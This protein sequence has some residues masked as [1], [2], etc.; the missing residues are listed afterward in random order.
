MT[1]NGKLCG[2][3]DAYLMGQDGTMM[4]GARWDNT[5]TCCSNVSI[6]LFT[7]HNFINLLLFIT[8]M[9]RAYRKKT[10]CG[11]WN[12]SDV[13]TT[14]TAVKNGE[15]SLREASQVYKI[16][17]STLERHKNNKVIKPG[18]LGRYST[19]LDIDYLDCH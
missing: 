9:V 4:I 2:I 17:K 18:S 10:T 7:S 13:N 12:L 15:L 1:D 5:Y 14:I 16:P 3:S 19:V 6:V 11:S 8:G